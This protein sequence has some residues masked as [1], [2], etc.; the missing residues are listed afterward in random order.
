MPSCVMENYSKLTDWHV[1]G[2]IDCRGEQTK[3]IAITT[4]II[5]RCL[6]S[7]NIKGALN[8]VT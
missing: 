5:T 6:S 1:H 2:F 7:T 4:S 3:G 8:L